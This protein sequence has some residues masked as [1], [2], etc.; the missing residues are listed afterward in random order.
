LEEA[1]TK[2]AT[3]LG[4]LKGQSW[5][6]I[7]Q[8]LGNLLAILFSPTTPVQKFIAAAEYVYRA[9]VKPHVEAA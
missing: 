8:N 5:Q 6:T 9:L 7:S 2:V 1:A 3:Y 4:S